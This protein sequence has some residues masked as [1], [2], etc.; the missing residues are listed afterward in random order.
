MPEYKN[1]DEKDSCFNIFKNRELKDM[2]QP[3]YEKLNMKRNK[4]KT[5]IQKLLN[6]TLLL[7]ILLLN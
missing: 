6:L 2:T 5:A 3:F 4:K 1:L 7:I